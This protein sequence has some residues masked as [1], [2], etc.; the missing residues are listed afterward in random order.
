[1]ILIVSHSLTGGSSG[2][3]FTSGLASG[4]D[5]SAVRPSSWTV[6]ALESR[7]TPHAH[8]TSTAEGTRKH[9]PARKHRPALIKP[10]KPTQHVAVFTPN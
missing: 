5:R 8:F 2:Y 10:T 9:G 7:L 4:T 3:G 6:G 1:M